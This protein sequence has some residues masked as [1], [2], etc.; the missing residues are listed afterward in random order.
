[1]LRTGRPRADIHRETLEQY[2]SLKFTWNQIGS[3]LGASSKT[4]QRRAKEWSIKT[5]STITDA[6]LDDLVKGI[7]YE[8]PNSGEVMVNG[9]LMSKKVC[10]W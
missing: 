2:R 7:L 4:V 9:H 8:F 1:M 3:L 10:E 5:Y 6:A